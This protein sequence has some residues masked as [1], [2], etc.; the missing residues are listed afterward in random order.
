[1][2]ESALDV[3]FCV[4]LWGGGGEGRGRC[5]MYDAHEAQNL[6]QVL[7]TWKLIDHVGATWERVS[8]LKC[9]PLCASK[10]CVGLVCKFADAVRSLGQY[11]S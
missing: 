11:L 7:V 3:H 5:C 1:M 9:V 8:H 6:A 2:R 4:C 10:L